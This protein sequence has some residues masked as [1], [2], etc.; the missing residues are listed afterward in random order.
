MHLNRMKYFAGYIRFADKISSKTGLVVSWLT[1]LLVLITCYDVLTRYVFNQS[2]VALQ[3][4]E[5]HLFALIFLLAAAYTLKT[6]GHVRVDVI[7][8]KLSLSKKAWINLTGSILFLIP[9]CVFVI[10][11]SLDFVEASWNFKETSPDSGGL[12][13]RYFLKTIIPISFLLLLIEAISLALKSFIHIMN[14]KY[15]T[16]AENH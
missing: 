11:S 5:W 14:K 13:G 6:D 3:E 1:L 9:F 8:T 15:L 12:P 16:R 2:S 4:L 7:Y 10:L